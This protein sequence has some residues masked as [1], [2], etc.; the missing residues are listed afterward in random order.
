[1]ATGKGSARKPPTAPGTYFLSLTVENVRCFGP[2]QTLD[3]SDGH[4]RHAPWT[5]I[6]GENGHGKTTLLTCLT[7]IATAPRFFGLGQGLQ[8]YGTLLS[9]NRN[10]R[11]VRGIIKTV[12]VGANGSRTI[13][14]QELRIGGHSIYPDN[15]TKDLVIY[16]YGASRRMPLTGPFAPDDRGAIFLDDD[17]ALRDPEDWLLKADYNALLQGAE[18]THFGKF[19][20]RVREAL[21]DILPEVDEIRIAPADAP[22]GSPRVEART[23]DGW[24]PLR[25]LGFGYQS[26]IAWLVDL[27]SRMFERY[28]DSTDPLA[29]PAVVL[30]DEIDLHMHPRWQRQ[31]IGYLTQRFPNTQFIVTAHSPL[32]VQAAAGAN[33]VLLRRQRD[34]VV[35]D[36]DPEVLDNWRVDQILTSELFGLPSARPPQIE[37]QLKE[38]RALLA[39]ARLSSRDRARIAE[40][41]AEIGHLPAGENAEDR[42]AMELIRR[43]A[44]KLQGGR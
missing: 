9:L 42:R 36:N 10:A 11:N 44:A 8:W 26:Q 7:M 20:E 43:A 23:P 2:A 22:G 24:I 18:A 29:E 30:V 13:I 12:A 38:R 41:E 27:A 28:P 5:I 19:A 3:L 33:I 35:I 14:E 1:M 17:V 16:N 39:K 4:G 37:D 34:H 25:R 21:V 40:L 15:A 32:V 6:L 31:L